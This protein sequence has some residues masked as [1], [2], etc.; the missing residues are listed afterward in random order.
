[1]AESELARQIKRAV[2]SGDKL[3]QDI[4]ADTADLLMTIRDLR[5]IFGGR[6]DEEEKGE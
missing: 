5:N 1:M 2:E 4:K 3:V 6:K